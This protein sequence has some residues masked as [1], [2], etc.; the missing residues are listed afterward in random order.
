MH[1]VPPRLAFLLLT[2]ALLTSMASGLGV[3]P[4]SHELT[5]EP[6]KTTTY[7]LKVVNNDG[8]ARQVLLYTDGELSS[9]ISLSDSLISFAEDEE[10]RIV[11]VTV[12]QP[13]RLAVQGRLQGRIIARDLSLTS[14]QLGASLSVV[15]RLDLIVPYTGTYAELKLFVGDLQAG[16][17]GNFV[18]ELANLGLEDIASAQVYVNVL[19][20]R[21]DDVVASLVS[22]DVRVPK[23][24]KKLF[25]IPWS[26]EVP[27]GVYKAVATAVYDGDSVEDQKV[28]SIGSRSVRVSSISVDD[29]SLG[30]IA[31]FDILLRNEWSG[32]IE[33][34]HAEV[35]V[36]RGESLFASST[37]QTITLQPLQSQAVNAYWDTKNVVTGG[38]DLVVTLFHGD[39][40]EE[41]VFPITVTQRGIDTGFT[42]QVV[43]GREGGESSAIYLLVALVVVVLVVNAVLFRK[44]FRRKK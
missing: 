20:A 5:F 17:Q 14:G 30:G 18:A 28:F 27:N 43:S 34:V 35:Q 22:D 19:D 39:A 42:A 10:E 21:T 25:T 36:R 15:S 40:V 4:S 41:R 23:G 31:K 16:K 1:R 13:E 38:Y 32:V 12:L 2:S 37:T 26:P 3:V 29:F 7:K 33:D 9:I 6:G 8:D 11:T 24:T 44:L